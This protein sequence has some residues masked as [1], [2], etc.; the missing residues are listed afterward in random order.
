MVEVNKS[1]EYIDDFITGEKI[2]LAG[3][4]ENRQT[5]ARILI[6]EK[7]FAKKD[8]RRD[9]PIEVSVGAESYRSKVDLVVTAGGR[10]LILFKC[11]AGS[12]GSREREALAA[13][14]LLENHPIPLSVVSDGK[15]AVV[16]D[17]ATGKIAGKGWEAVPTKQQALKKLAAVV[18][19]ELP[20]ERRQKE[21]LIFRSYDS[22][23]VN[24]V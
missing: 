21:G 12:L 1:A 7:G 23:N 18:L 15:T 10:S 22:M 17:T 24:I 11:A 16:L 19:K 6:S 14:R 2:P 20:P 9:V 13:A 4:E 8:L 5:V 3:A